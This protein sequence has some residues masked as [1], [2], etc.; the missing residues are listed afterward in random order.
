MEGLMW[1]SVRLLAVLVLLLITAALAFA[2]EAVVTRNVNLRRD[3]STV[4]R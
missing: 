4:G 2:Q 3:P 1:R